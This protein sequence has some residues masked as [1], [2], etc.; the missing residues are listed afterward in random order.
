MRS[1][2]HRAP[3]SLDSGTHRTTR[4][5][6]NTR[7]TLSRGL[8]ANPVSSPVPAATARVAAATVS[9]N[10]RHLALGEARGYEPETS[11]ARFRFALLACWFEPIE[12]AVDAAQRAREGLIAGGDLTH[13]GYPHLTHLYYLLDCSPSL[14][15]C[16]AR[17]LAANSSSNARSLCLDD[18]WPTGRPR[19]SAA[20]RAD[21]R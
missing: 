15:S 11:E 18:P 2:G 20:L 4:P 8:P 1:A 10:Q 7:G 5:A 13:A 19:R 12:N 9:L 16:V 21:L 3:T 6:V 14:A 17:M